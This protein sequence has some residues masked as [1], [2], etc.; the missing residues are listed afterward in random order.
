MK[1]QMYTPQPIDTTDVGN[2]FDNHLIE[3]REVRIFLSS[4]FSDMDEERSALVRIF[5]KLRLE[6]NRR[7][8]SLTLLDLRWGVT[9]KESRTGK[10]L[11]VCL[12]EIENSHPFFIG[13]L[14]GRYGYS[15]NVSEL[16]K[17][18]ELEE[19][20]PWLRDDIMQQLSITVIEIQYGVLR[21]EEGVDACF[22]I[23]DTPDTLP[24]DD[25]KLTTLKS[26]IREQKR[27][28]VGE[29]KSIDHLCQQ[30]ETDV[31]RLLD[32]YFSV[33]D[34]TRLGRER[35]VQKSYINSRHR[36]YI[37]RKAD[38]DRLNQFLLGDERHLVVTGPSGMGKSALIA[39][40]LNSL[41][42]KKDF[43]Y[44]IIYHFVGNI[45]GGNGKEEVLQHISDELFKF[46]NGLE[47]KL[48]N[49]ESL[50]EKTQRYMTEAV[51]G[52]GKPMLIVIDGINQIDENQQAKLLNWLPQSPKRVKYLFSTL[53]NDATMQSFHRL[54]Y[55]IYSIGALDNNQRLKFIIGYLSIVGKK[56]DGD[57]IEQ[58]LQCKVATNTLVLKTILDELIC[59]GSHDH[60]NERANFYLSATSV[61]DFFNKMLQRLEKDYMDVRRVLSLIAL[62]EHGLTEDELVGITGLRQMDFHLFYCAI[63]A[64]LVSRGG[65]L[66][67]AHQYITDSIWNRYQL[68]EAASSK[69]YREELI[70]YF[71]SN[72]IS[73]RNRQISELAF[74]YYQTDDYE[75]LYKMILSF[76]AFA[77]FCETIA[78]EAHLA[79]YWRKLRSLKHGKYQLRD[80]LD[81]P[82]DGISVP[83][84]PYL[85]IQYFILTYFADTD[86]ALMYVKTYLLM[87]QLSGD[88]FSLGVAT[89]YND[90]GGI[91]QTRGDYDQA[92][93]YQE[94]ALE[95]RI[96]LLGTKDMTIA[97]SYNNIGMIFEAQCEYD[98]AI[99]YLL[100]AL[101]ICEEMLGP[102]H[103]RTA[104]AMDNLGLAYQG[105][106][107]YD[108]A[109]RYH[110][111]A[112]E[113]F[114]KVF[115]P[116]YPDT[117]D[118]Y[119]NVGLAY[120]EKGE[121]DMALKYHE[122]ALEI[123]LKILGPEHP[124]SS[125][126]Y[127]NIGKVYHHQGDFKQ[128]LQYFFIGLEIQKKTHGLKHPVISTTYNDIGG[129][130]DL[131]GEYDHALAYYHKALA[132]S[133]EVL[134]EHVKTAT[135]YYN[136]ACVW[137]FQEKYDEALDYHL[138]ALR[139]RERFL[140]KNHPDLGRSYNN[141][142]NVFSQRGNYVQALS[143]FLKAIAILEKGLSPTHPDTITNYYNIGNV[144][145]QMSDLDNAVKWLRK[146][147]E[148]GDEDS[149]MTLK[150]LGFI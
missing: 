97:T 120:L 103:P 23:K 54:K 122:R 36:F 58:I 142:G 45:F 113:V 95:I 12:N 96:R 27:F 100:K 101:Y 10:V 72:D 43:S 112:M 150:L 121:Y 131:L 119:N 29:Y 138:R 109:L 128:A 70:Y 148:Q 75:N 57:M 34:N 7:N 15:P 44:N 26:K 3:N 125:Y 24:D 129:S 28:P 88:L 143:Y 107:E 56:L 146:A 104:M 52:E 19:R 50:E 4:T 87:L 110:L 35:N 17:N 73:D 144:Y 60:L 48:G 6:A 135:Y 93:D 21:N 136:I 11:S 46:Y 65:L 64:H 40:W 32:K 149:I 130:Y 85:R 137:G 98:R 117:A 16:D 5:H 67:F 76:D 69:P 49:H 140:K 92:Q 14:G 38:S 118:S 111:E 132:I 105:I 80:Y 37:P 81:L 123:R 86:T 51:Q 84:L 108:I 47:I 133:E 66:V 30:V 91:Y 77:I 41:E 139:I 71:S 13:L 102:E 145:L 53:E 94:R 114:E 89:C 18:P 59:F 9:D 39:N 79:S 127:I 99:E 115:G 62:S 78:W 134:G 116:E 33:K 42:Q 63:S 147:A 83:D 2:R 55:P 31:L 82:Y 106:E 25:K 61:P 124:E 22:F 20:Y 1:K 68:Q 74:Q 8:V 141:I 126:S 90:I